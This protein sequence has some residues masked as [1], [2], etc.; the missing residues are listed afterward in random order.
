MVML[1]DI[2]TKNGNLDKLVTKR[3]S[4]VPGC[5]LVTFWLRGS[6]EYVINMNCHLRHRHFHVA[7]KMYDSK[8][9]LLCKL[10]ELNINQGP[11]LKLPYVK[12]I[13]GTVWHYWYC[14]AGNCT[15]DW[16]LLCSIA[17]SLSWTLTKLICLSMPWVSHSFWFSSHIAAWLEGKL[18]GPVQS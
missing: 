14:T 7:I 16:W 3:P 12:E 1:T 2:W 11:D 8:L 10:C 13:I 6:R 4:A 9:S 15:D 17:F 18:A 5:R